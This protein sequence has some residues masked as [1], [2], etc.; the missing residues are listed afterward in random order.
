MTKDIYDTPITIKYN[1]VIGKVY[2]P[3]LT[4]AEYD[5]RM[6]TIKKAAARLV[7]SKHDKH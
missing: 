6:N 4:K 2:S 7:M 5:E 3:I 1:N